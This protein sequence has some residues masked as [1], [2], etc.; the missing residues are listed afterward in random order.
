MLAVKAKGA[1]SKLEN[2]LHALASTLNSQNGTPLTAKERRIETERFL[3][4]GW[5][6][7]QVARAIGVGQ[8]TLTQVKQEI[9]ATTRIKRV[10]LANGHLQGASL[11]ALGKSPVLA[12]ND[13]PYRE[14]VDLASTAGL[15]SK[16]II[17]IAKAAKETGS[18]DAAI[19]SLAKVRAE[20]GERIR[21]HELTGV[22]KPP[23]SRML[24]QHLGFVTRFAGEESALVETN[25][26]VVPQHIEAITTSIAI[27]Q[28]VLEAQEAYA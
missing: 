22:S 23:V 27:L 5:K 25:R 14:L 17:A 18:D 21:E 28:R 15:N 10:G 16:E 6:A 9:D 20:M 7:E 13:V 2:E 24:R 8:G 12:L 4:L 11:R 26:E 1:S 19:E 3:S